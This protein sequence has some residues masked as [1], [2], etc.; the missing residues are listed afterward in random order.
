MNFLSWNRHRSHSSAS[1]ITSQ[2]DAT[3]PLATGVS[4]NARALKNDVKK[5]DKTIAKISHWH[6]PGWNY[7]GATR[8]QAE[9]TQASIEKLDNKVIEQLV[10]KKRTSE[11][12]HTF[13]RVLTTYN[14]LYGE[15]KGAKTER[16]V[17]QVLVDSTRIKTVEQEVKDLV[18][19]Y[20]D[21]NIET[22]FK[23]IVLDGVEKPDLSSIIP[24]ARAERIVTWLVL[25][26]DELA[27]LESLNIPSDLVLHNI[28]IEFLNF[29]PNLRT[30]S[31]P[32][33][34]L[35]SLPESLCV[36]CPLLEII[37]VHG[38][39][40]TSVP[41][42]LTGMVDLN[43][44]TQRLCDHNIIEIFNCLDLE[45]SDKP[46]FGHV[47]EENTVILE[48]WLLENKSLLKSV[49]ALHI[50]LGSSIDEL[51]MRIFQYFPNLT[52]I[53]CPGGKLR[54]LPGRL[55]EACPKLNK[56]NVEKNYLQDV[57]ASLSDLVDLAVQL[58]RIP[59]IADNNTEIFFKS[60][61]LSGKPTEN[62]SM[63]EKE[64]WLL[65]NLQILKTIPRIEISAD[66]YLTT[67]PVCV[68]QYFPNL[69]S[70]SCPF[71]K[72]RSLQENL[73]TMCPRLEFLNVEG[74]L[75]TPEGI[76]EN[77]SHLVNLDVQKQ[78]IPVVHD[79]NTRI[80]IEVLAPWM[81]SEPDEVMD[82][83]LHDNRLVLENARSSL[84]IDP[85]SS[86]SELPSCILQYLPNLRSISCPFNELRSLPEP[87]S[88]F[89]SKLTAIDV[90][91]NWITFV[92]ASLSHLV[93]LEVQTQR[94]LIE[95]KNCTQ[96]FSD[97]QIRNIED[98][99]G[100]CSHALELAASSKG[101]SINTAKESIRTNL[102]LLLGDQN[103]QNLSEKHILHTLSK[104]AESFKMILHKISDITRKKNALVEKQFFKGSA[105][106]IPVVNN[107]ISSTKA[108]CEKI[109]SLKD[110]LAVF[111]D[112]ATFQD[113]ETLA[114]SLL[115]TPD[116]CLFP[117]KGEN[118]QQDAV[119]IVF[120]LENA[121]D[122]FH[123][124]TTL[125]ISTLDLQRCPERFIKTYLKD[126][127]TIRC[128][129]MQIP[130][131]KSFA[132][133]NGIIISAIESES[134][135]SDSSLGITF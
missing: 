7:K 48:D 26:Q 80:L 1:D 46:R 56:I 125:D 81:K 130:I 19:L 10:V 91:G 8:K 85:H 109:C 29:L 108:L 88:Q 32:D 4:Q 38:N 6:L 21:P 93:N 62:A 41:P 131:F 53:D 82:K 114:N 103:Y 2:T 89:C 30:L 96:E 76:P 71:A 63:D 104:N 134:F 37:D 11:I 5:L 110:S 68:L 111:S 105:K 100:F 42:S 34:R 3:I 69:T 36:K 102:T 121:R 73:S 49:K 20:D 22:L 25:N 135:S 83:W 78:R 44:Q 95:F 45:A 119:V 12:L 99:L 57:P 47:Q 94:K 40:L 16:S 39:F 43:V 74:N 52:E 35:K 33:N 113:T 128:T 60:I 106:T 24:S 65:K 90:R 66:S 51:P 9:K 54:S 97:Y 14:R 70:I 31:C 23:A 13:E 124:L 75:L 132:E 77:L 87:L 61:P 58:Q 120:L 55:R 15:K 101:S 79:A 118:Q 126:V 18:A 107:F 17:A 133:G 28:S 84:D 50:P 67:F 117:A 127:T 112:E 86:L 116:R 123:R 92:P 59:M 122:S 64:L 129:T 115:N 27:L 72:L 98:Q